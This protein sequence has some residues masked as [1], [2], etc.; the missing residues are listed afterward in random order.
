M[1]EF[2]S[3]KRMGSLATPH[4]TGKDTESQEV[5]FFFFFCQIFTATLAQ[6]YDSSPASLHGL[7]PS[8]SCVVLSALIVT[9]WYLSGNH[10]LIGQVM[11]REQVLL[12]LCCPTGHH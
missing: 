11:H 7:P 9:T 6:K 5:D 2:L 12:A 4:L 8:V 3:V 10:Y 1:K